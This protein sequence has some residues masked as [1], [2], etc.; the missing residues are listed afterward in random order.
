MND[1]TSSTYLQSTYAVTF[2]ENNKWLFAKSNQCVTMGKG[3]SSLVTLIKSL[4]RSKK[5]KIVVWNYHLSEQVAWS[6]EENYD[7]IEKHSL[8]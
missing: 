1:N 3:L 2:L 7:K 8:N 6:G 5:R 4:T